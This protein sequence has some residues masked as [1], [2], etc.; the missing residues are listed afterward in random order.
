MNDNW[1][2]KGDKVI[3]QHRAPRRE[4]YVPVGM[5]VGSRAGKTLKFSD[6]RKT[7]VVNNGNGEMH[8]LEDN[9]RQVGPLAL[10]YDWTGWSELTVLDE[11]ANMET[12]MPGVR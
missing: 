7:Q 9:W 4:F 6:A 1:V 11:D 3:R 8:E 10:D 5:P 2:F 12:Y